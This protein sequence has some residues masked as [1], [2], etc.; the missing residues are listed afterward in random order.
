[1][2]SAVGLVPPVIWKLK[3]LVNCWIFTGV[4]YQALAASEP[5]PFVN[6]S[7]DPFSVALPFNFNP[8]EVNP[9]P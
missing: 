9:L 5:P 3:L 6:S 4:L 8:L 2:P 7:A 1:M